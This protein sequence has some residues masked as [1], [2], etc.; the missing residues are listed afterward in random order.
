MPN[1]LDDVK[2]EIAKKMDV[3]EMLD[4]LD[5]TMYDLVEVLGGAILD[6][7][8]EFKEALR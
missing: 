5:Y 3:Y 2:D 8:E 6:K 4:V 1:E 7:L